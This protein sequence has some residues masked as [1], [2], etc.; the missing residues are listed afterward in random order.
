[1]F[2]VLFVVGWFASDGDAPDYAADQLV[3]T[4]IDA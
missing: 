2:A 4:E 1:V 3:A